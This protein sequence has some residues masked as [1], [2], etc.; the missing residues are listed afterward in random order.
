MRKQ[1]PSFDKRFKEAENPSKFW[2]AIGVF[3]FFGTIYIIIK[4]FVK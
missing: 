3:A 4:Y 1:Y 2:A